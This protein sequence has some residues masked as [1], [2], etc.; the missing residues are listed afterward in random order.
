MKFELLPV[1]DTMLELYEKTPASERFEAY[2]KLLQGNTKGDLELPIGG[3]NPM[4]K[5]HVTT[6]LLELKA[7]GAEALMSEVLGKLNAQLDK[8]SDEPVFRVVLNLSDDL[9][10][11]WTNRYISDYDSKFKLNALVTRQFC[12]P[13]FWSGENYTRQLVEERTVEYAL[14]T[15]YWLRHPKPI[16]LQQHIEQEKFVAEN[17]GKKSEYL[18]DFDELHAFYEK[19]KNSD[20]YDLIFNFLYGDE[21]C[22]VLGYPCY[23]VPGLMPGYG[24]A[25]LKDIL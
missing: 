19:H 17:S 5:A 23:G 14:R 20:G 10:G 1:I 6:K 25:A 3:F 13:I 16:T 15:L 9:K 24:Y 4:A 12:T 22:R 21:A 11:G 18:K 2:L 8:H 7:L